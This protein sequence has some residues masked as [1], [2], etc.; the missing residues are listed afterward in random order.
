MVEAV[1]GHD[2]DSTKRLFAAFRTL[3]QTGDCPDCAEALAPMQPLAAVHE[4]PSRIKCATLPWH[5]LIA[6]LDDKGIASS[7]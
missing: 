6:A 7:E 4:Y 1:V 2:P 5:A 3:A